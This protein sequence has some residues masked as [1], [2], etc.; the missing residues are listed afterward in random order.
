M[1]AAIRMKGPCKLHLVQLYIWTI[2][3]HRSTDVPVLF[4]S[5]LT[6]PHTRE[7]AVQVN[8]ELCS[9]SETGIALQAV[10]PHMQYILKTDRTVSCVYLT[11][12]AALKVPCMKD[13]VLPQ[14]FLLLS[15]DESCILQEGLPFS[16]AMPSL[17]LCTSSAYVRKPVLIWP[18][19]ANRASPATGT[20]RK[21]SRSCCKTAGLLRVGSRNLLANNLTTLKPRLFRSCAT[22]SALDWKSVTSSGTSSRSPPITIATGVE[23]AL[24]T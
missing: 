14:S 20:F 12:P 13:S 4:L 23:T 6:C 21:V 1:D 7:A 9:L 15:D 16:M 19:Y 5:K 10:C 3:Q 8:Q 22:A 18:M 2:G 17:C 24:Q 11:L